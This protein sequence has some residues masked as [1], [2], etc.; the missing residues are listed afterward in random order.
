MT[1]TQELIQEEL[2]MIAKCDREMSE[3]KY[4]SKEWREWKALKQG[5]ERNLLAARLVNGERIKVSCCN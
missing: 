5:C 1:T 2:D 4:Y 3:A